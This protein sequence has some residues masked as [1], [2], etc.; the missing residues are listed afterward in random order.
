M[1][2]LLIKQIASTAIH[3]IL[4]YLHGSCHSCKELPFV[5]FKLIIKL[6]WNIAPGIILSIRISSVSTFSS[7]SSTSLHFG[8]N[9]A[10]FPRQGKFENI[11][12]TISNTRRI[13]FEGIWLLLLKNNTFHNQFT[14]PPLLYQTNYQDHQS[15]QE[16][17]AS[18][19]NAEARLVFG[20]LSTSCKWR[21]RETLNQ[22]WVIS[23]IICM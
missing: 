10:N 7:N 22:V 21:G 4:L 2:P 12:I 17:Q 20:P 13:R 18:Q 3:S 9:R 1:H 6:N 14:F 23:T 8:V 5:Y 19:L 16:C 15:I 11:S